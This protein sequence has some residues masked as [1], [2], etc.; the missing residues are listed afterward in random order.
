MLH[1]AQIST[2]KRDEMRDITREVMSYVK[3]E[4]GP[5]RNRR[6]LLSAHYSRDCY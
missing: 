3:K 2:S 5:K 1:T 4:R 6:C